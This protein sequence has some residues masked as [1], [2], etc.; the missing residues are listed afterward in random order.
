MNG[1]EQLAF[2]PNLVFAGTSVAGGRGEAV[3]FAIG[4]NTE[5]GRIARLNS[6][7]ADAAIAALEDIGSPRALII[8]ADARSTVNG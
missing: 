4:A 3:T 6:H 5:F 2:Y 7:L 1:N 8:A